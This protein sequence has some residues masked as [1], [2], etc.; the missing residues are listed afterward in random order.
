MVPLLTSRQAY[1]P[2]YGNATRHIQLLARRTL[3]E[4]SLAC[5]S[6][7][8][9]S[10]SCRSAANAASSGLSPAAAAAA[11]AAPACTPLLLGPA[12]AGA[13]AAGAGAEAVP[14]S[15]GNSSAAERAAVEEDSDWESSPSGM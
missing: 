9:C 8:S 10:I 6:S 12:G 3:K 11:G 2:P 13:A 14:G 4:A 7:L 5:A 1:M 15:G